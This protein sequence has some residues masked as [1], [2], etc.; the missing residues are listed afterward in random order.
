MRQLK[1]DFVKGDAFE[2][3]YDNLMQIC[4][5]HE[6]GK[7]KLFHALQQFFSGKKSTGLPECSFSL[8]GSILSSSHF[9]VISIFNE[10]D[11]L[12]E[13]TYSKDSVFF[14]TVKGLDSNHDFCV[15]LELV[16][17]DLLK[18]DGLIETYLSEMFSYEFIVESKEISV[19]EYFK[20]HIKLKYKGI[21]LEE[22]SNFNRFVLFLLMLKNQALNKPDSYLVSIYD[23]DKFLSLEEFDSLTPFLVD[24]CENY[25]VSFILFSGFAGFIVDDAS[26][27]DGIT[28][29]N[30]I[31]FSFSELSL[32]RESIVRN[33]PSNIILDD[34]SI[35]KFIRCC[36]ADLFFHG[37]TYGYTRNDVIIKLLN[38]FYGVSCKLGEEEL[39]GALE[40]AFLKGQ[41]GR[42]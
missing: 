32:L 34:L 39:V 6:L 22:L 3:H 27:V 42:I 40:L 2:F 18:L 7:R 33:Y 31:S 10:M 41:Q 21:D 24:L 38:S 14:E 16:N 26:Y 5:H 19:T 17:N 23:I 4:G 37:Y 20:S 30:D 35:F 36:A 28:V 9:K 15:M 1:V 8:E 13:I 25:S 29:L 11:L 12:N